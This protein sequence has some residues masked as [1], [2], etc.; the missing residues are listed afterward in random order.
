MTQAS[1]PVCDYEGSDY[2]ERF[3]E[4]GGREYED[5]VEA[6][7]LQRLLPKQG[8]LLLEVGAGAG[9]NTP[10]YTGFQRVV[11]VDYSATQL[12]QAQSRLDRSSRYAFV[13]ANAYHLPFADGVFDAAS[14]IRT[15]HHMADPLAALQQ[16]RNTLLP[17]AAFVLEYANKCNLKAIGRW[18]LR[19]QSWNPFNQQPIEFVPL[20]FDFHPAAVRRWL[21]VCDYRIDRQLTVSHFRLRLLKRLIPLSVLVSLDSLAQW[22]GNWWQLTPS[23]FIGARAVGRKILPSPGEFWRCPACGSTQLQEKE[24]AVVC[25][26]C[27]REWPRQDGIY[28]FRVE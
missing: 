16:V 9:R 23:V 21:R 22:T 13:A 27:G 4:R 7:A 14:M 11:L 19:R 24:S 20:N 18:V 1:P 8:A 3:W 5:R 12:Q 26:G 25:H 17:G 6:I 2:Q 28:D 10:R 15:L